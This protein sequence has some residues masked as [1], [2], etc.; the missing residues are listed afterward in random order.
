[1]AEREDVRAGDLEDDHPKAD[2]SAAFRFAC[3]L[4]RFAWMAKPLR[5]LATAYLDATEDVLEGIEV[6]D[7]M[8]TVMVAAN[9]Q[10]QA[11]QATVKML[12]GKEI[13]SM[14]IIPWEPGQLGVAIKY[15]NGYQRM[16]AVEYMPNIDPF[17]DGGRQARAHG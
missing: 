9:A 11:S 14:Q 2:H 7:Q 6:V 15:R 12:E 10:L 17:A 1:M 16:Q 5:N 3:W 13:E 8:K 4:E